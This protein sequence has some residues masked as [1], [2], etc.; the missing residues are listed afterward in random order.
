MSTGLSDK[1]RLAPSRPK[2]QEGWGPI[3]VGDRN[4]RDKAM[5]DPK[6]YIS[7]R[8]ETYAEPQR[9][10]FLSVPV[11]PVLWGK[12]WNRAALGF[13]KG[14]R[15]SKVRVTTGEATTDHVDWRV[16]VLISS[17]GVI[18]KIYQEIEVGLETNARHAADMLAQLYGRDGDDAQSVNKTFENVS[19]PNAG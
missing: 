17:D 10:G 14:L 15:P 2:A 3:E 5:K 12:P 9:I 16:T 4:L 1:P 8:G 11:M 6:D 7:T 19:L 18:R 13:L